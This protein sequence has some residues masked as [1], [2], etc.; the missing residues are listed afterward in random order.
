MKRLDNK[1]KISVSLLALMSGGALI[2]SSAHAVTISGEQNAVVITTDISDLTVDSTGDVSPGGI[3]VQGA[4]AGSVMN[5]GV[6]EFIDTPSAGDADYVIADAVGLEVWGDIGGNFSNTKT[7]IATADA[8]VSVIGDFSGDPS[9]SED[10]P[11]GAEA[12][13]GGVSL[14]NVDGSISNAGTITANATAD[15]SSDITADSAKGSSDIDGGSQTYAAAYGVEG[16]LDEGDFT[17][18]KDG[19]I[20]ATATA[21]SDVTADVSGTSATLFNVDDVDAEAFALGVALDGGGDAIANDGSIAAAASAT[22]VFNGTATAGTD[23]ALIGGE[24]FG[25][26]ADAVSVGL[27][28]GDDATSVSNTGSVTADAKASGTLNADVDGAGTGEIFG[29]NGVYAD[30]YGI[31]VDGGLASFANS[32]TVTANGTS[33]LA[34]DAIA[35]GDDGA[36]VV[37]DNQVGGESFGVIID[38][39]DGPFSNSGAISSTNSADLKIIADAG[40]A[41]VAPG[42]IVSG[43]FVKADAW[44]VLID[45]FD[46]SFT[47]AKDGKIT[48][49]ASATSSID[50]AATGATAAASDGVAVA[51]TITMANAI[52]V[53]L[54]GGED[55]EED[56]DTNSVTNAG[57]ISATAKATS[58]A[59]ASGTSTGTDASGVGVSNSLTGALA[60]G[61]LDMGDATGFDNSGSITATA[62]ASHTAT[63][64]GD[65]DIDSVASNGGTLYAA[66][67]GAAFVEPIDGNVS[68]SGTISASATGTYD[69]DLASDN[70]DDLGDISSSN[71]AGVAAVG[72]YADIEAPADSKD[73]ASTFTNSG[74]ISA[75]GNLTIDVTQPAATKDVTPDQETLGGLVVAGA[76]VAGDPSTVTNSG[77]IS[78]TG[79]LTTTGIAGEDSGTAAGV[80]GLWLP[81]ADDGLVVNNSGKITAELS[82]NAD[83][84]AAVGLLLGPLP[85]GLLDGLLDGLIGEDS[86][87]PAEVLLPLAEGDGDAEALA[88]GVIT[89]NNTGTIS[90]INK[91]EGGLGYGIFAETAPVPVV[92]N[93]MGG[94]IEGTTAAIAM[95]QGNA[96]TLN[97]SGG[98]IKGLVDADSADVVNVI[99]AQDKDGKGVATTVTAGT[100]FTLEGAGEF[101]IGNKGAPV[102]FVMNGLATNVAETNLNT[103]GKLVVG[104]TGKI[105]TGTFNQND[106]STLVIQFNPTKAG[107]ITTTGDFN[108]DGTLQTQ[109]LAGLYGD[110][111]SHIVIDAG[112]VVAGKFDSVGAVGDTLLIDF[113]T[114]VNPSDVTV[115]WERNG[116]DEVDGLSDNSKSVAGVIEDT[117]DPSR[118]P[119][120]NT[121]ELNDQ[122]GGLF[123]LTDAGLYDRV[124]NSWSGSEHAQVM[125]AAT[126]LSE[127]YLMALGEHLNDNRNTGFKQQ[128]VV[129]LLPKGST[130]IA[131]ASSVGQSGAEDSRLS[132]WGRGFGRWASTRGD[133]NADGYDEDTYGAVLGMD[134]NLSPTFLVGV[135]G[136]YIDDSIDF[137]DNDRASIKRWSIGG[138]ASATWDAFYVDGSFT[139]ASDN[140]KV[141]RTIL[142]GGAACLAYNCTADASSKY[143]GD[144][145]IVHAESGFNW[146]LGETARLQPFAGLNYTSIDHNGFS[147]TGGGDL[148]L[149]GVDGTGKSLQSRLGARLSGEW[150]SGNVKWVPEV[151]AEWRHEFKDNP[152]W[153]EASLVGLPSQSFTTGGSQVGRD[154][155]VVGAGISAQ[156]QGGWGLFFDYQGAFSSGYNSH[157]AQGGVRVKF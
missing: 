39:L 147:E 85:D 50:L 7:I 12:Y 17:N 4:V 114:V 52:G 129:Q 66:A 77:T 101:N 96:D 48:A 150:G 152:A 153:I 127:P 131:P 6:I 62:T 91:S 110:K 64:T 31:E 95:D 33:T 80:V 60:I 11:S 30:A 10:A 140:Y 20:K 40:A 34:I 79:S 54:N 126:N 103:D 5:N 134:F 53:S 36:T 89:V 68:N 49:D 56:P 46:G 57:S 149:V 44:G 28:I 2:A 108:A 51:D 98:T 139:Y 156:F 135:V 154:M 29:D 45:D 76:V 67:V 148:G 21:S 90:G 72:L 109:A 132:F 69:I 146:L 119:S 16:T 3:L 115:S 113:T 123:T 81:D 124:L 58:T 9:I 47:N 63:L 15:A 104:P 100:D 111:G 8:S 75:T 107:L 83:D 42:M 84:S 73:P 82:G 128:K 157:I 105:D 155:A 102:T 117:Y 13:A 130:S 78:A 141:D 116:F 94:T 87:L 55:T 118:P 151:R 136:S 112:G 88:A 14:G 18:T 74:T 142:T 22:S 125:R 23:D 138:Y 99:Q 43:S 137:D 32:G 41:D 86:V 27:Y 25:V 19:A 122:L 24:D 143:G 144:G 37:L 26:V 70:A 93:Q 38:S 59:T 133:A 35:T 65:G 106:G 145:W 92:I 71:L 1:L 97:W 121:P 61:L 120:K